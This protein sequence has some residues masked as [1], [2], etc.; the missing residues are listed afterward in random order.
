[1]K[2]S[3]PMNLLLQSFRVFAMLTILTGV[4]YPLVVTGISWLCFRHQANGSLIV[5]DG[6]IVGSSLLAQ[7]FE[8]DR[9]FWPRPS[10]ADYATVASGASNLGP[11]SEKLQKQ[12][13]ERA[14]ALG[15]AHHVSADAPLPTDMLYASG[16]GL[17]PHISPEAAHLQ[18]GRV[19][20]ARRIEERRVAELVERSV[21]KPQL[22]IL[23]EARVNVLTLNLALDSMR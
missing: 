11:A 1:M 5:R 12:I 6:K 17:D 10:A 8:G 21:E 22:A 9:Y 13:A 19:A 4:F 15:D 23:G 7:K 18:V 3:Q 16:S 2:T 14:T 20:K